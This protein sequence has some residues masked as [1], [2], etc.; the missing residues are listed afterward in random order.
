MSAKDPP[1]LRRWVGWGVKKAGK[2]G[3]KVINRK[4]VRPRAVPPAFEENSP[5]NF[6]PLTT[7]Y[8]M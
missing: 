5:V 2:Q 4:E 1:N 7:K 3:Y 8:Y 6:G